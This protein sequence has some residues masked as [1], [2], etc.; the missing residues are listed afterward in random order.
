MT[1]KSQKLVWDTMRFRP[2]DN[3]RANVKT[4]CLLLEVE[5]GVRVRVTDAARIA[6]EE[7]VARRQ[8]KP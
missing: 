4:L 7:A 6:I 1:K 5:K 3:I 8:A 2:E